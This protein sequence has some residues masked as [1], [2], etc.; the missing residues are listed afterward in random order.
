MEGNMTRDRLIGITCVALVAFA[1]GL[2]SMGG[3]PGVTDVTFNRRFIPTIKPM[4][5]YDQIVK[6]A[7]APGLKIGEDKNSSP[8]AV[9]YR[10]Q[11][12]R[13]SVLT[14][15]V[16]NNKMIDATVLG[17]NKHTYLIRNNGEVTD[18]TK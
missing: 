10:W 18:I 13:G 8:P 12:S 15:R 1:F 14:A 7:G 17:P 9:Q 3:Q 6:I 5:T 11:G 16:S 2:M 4:M